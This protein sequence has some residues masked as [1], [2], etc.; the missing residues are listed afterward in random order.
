MEKSISLFKYLVIILTFCWSCTSSK[1]QASLKEMRFK[2]F[3]YIQKQNGEY[4]LVYQID[5]SGER[6]MLIKNLEHKVWN[7][8][9]YY[10]FSF[11]LSHPEFGQIKKWPVK[12]DNFKEFAENNSIYWLNPDS[13][14]VK[15]DIRQE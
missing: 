6:N 14:E 10:Y 8:K 13:S 3:P 15:L 4:F 1:P 11:Q 7:K 12:E 9:A 2:V 5:T